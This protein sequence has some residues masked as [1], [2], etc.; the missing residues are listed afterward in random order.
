MDFSRNGDRLVIASALRTPIGQ[1]GKSLSKIQ[2]YDLASLVTEEL[3]KKSKVDKKEID[4][5]VAG[6]I[7]QSSRA[8][9]VARVISVKAGH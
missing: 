7:A 5:V 9:N 1:S 4:G 8:P 6:E 3:F 2:S